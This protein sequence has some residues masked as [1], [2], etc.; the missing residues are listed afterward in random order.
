MTDWRDELPAELKDD[1]S[2]KDF[3]DVA[4]VARSLV[5]TKKMVGDSIRIPRADA[6]ADARKEFLGKLLEKVPEV[7][8]LPDDPAERAAVEGRV[9]EKL[10]RPSKPEEYLVDP[11][12]LPAGVTLNEAQLREGAAK[13]GLTKAQFKAEVVEQV[14][15]A[16]ARAAAVK[17]TH[18]ALRGEFGAGYE[19]K[20]KGAAVVASAMGFPPDMVDAIRSGSMPLAAAKAF[21]ST[22]AKV[23]T[24]PGQVSGQ[25]HGGTPKVTPSEAARRLEVLRDDPKY[26]DGHHPE[27]HKEAAELTALLGA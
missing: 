4:S 8:V 5:E 22:A 18:D 26:W 1:P 16:S 15:A 10:G 11:A 27:M 6:G 20:L 23:T 13:L 17:A 12:D 2:L 24:D 25:G 21:L 19:E 14:A 7:V 3:K 9:W